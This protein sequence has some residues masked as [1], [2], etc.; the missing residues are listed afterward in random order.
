MVL[1]F[2][3]SRRRHS[4]TGL[5]AS[6]E[7]NAIPEP[8]FLVTFDE[9]AVAESAAR[10][11][12][13][14]V[15]AFI[16]VTILQRALSPVIRLAI[17]E[18]MQGEPQIEVTKRIDTLSHVIY[19]TLLFVV[20]AIVIVTILPEFGVNAAALIAGLGLFGLAVGFGAQ[21]L[22]KDVI[23][24]IFILAENQYGV[25]DVVTIAG[26]IGVVEDINL[27]RTVLRDLDGVVHF[28][29]HGSINVAS[30]WT[31]SYSRVNL[32]VGV[33]YDSNL[34][35]VIEVINR[36]GKEL[37]EDPEFSSKIIDPPHVLRVDNFGDSSIDIKIIGE[38][39]PIEQWGIM[40]ELRLRLKKA[41][42][43][44]GIEIPFPQ[45]TVH[46]AVAAASLPD[47]LAPEPPVES[48][49][50]AG[51]PGDVRLDDSPN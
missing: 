38:T 51:E 19:R 17:S 25:G 2:V 47:R 22:V 6:T 31:K 18:Q 20:M 9:D 40:G 41:F 45:R 36:V 30:N 26:I 37:S 50:A 5:N 35:H 48:R 4:Y 3:G 10:I 43:A 21:N 7:G 27:R 13:I 39:A 14:I 42:D 29:G 28:V 11:G 24:G 34:D 32:N 12:L 46:M 1:W 8:L 16:L 33:A 49:H 23:N 44:E 15:A